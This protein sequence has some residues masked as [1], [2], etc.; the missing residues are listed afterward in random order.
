MLYVPF[1]SLSLS[2]Y[3]YISL[4]LDPKSPKLSR[5]ERF[6]FEGER[7]D[8]IKGQSYRI[9]QTAHEENSQKIKVHT[10]FL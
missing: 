8:T 10:H 6:F 4:L 9:Y 7:K 5:S 3:K 2:L 1:A